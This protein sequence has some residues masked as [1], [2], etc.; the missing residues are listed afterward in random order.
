MIVTYYHVIEVFVKREGQVHT[1]NA[2]I[3]NFD[4]TNDINLLQIDDSLFTYFLHY[5]IP[6]KFRH[7]DVK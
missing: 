1:A 5:H 2:K 4:K 6:L 3:P 7:R